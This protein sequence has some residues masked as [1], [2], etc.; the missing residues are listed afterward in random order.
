V[1]VALI[2]ALPVVMWLTT[3]L[4]E[5]LP[6]EPVPAEGRLVATEMGRVYVEEIG[7]AGGTPVLLV[8][9]SVGWAGLWRET[10]AALAAAGYHAIAF[11]MPPMGWSDRDPAATYD[12]ATQGRRVLALTRA[13]G[14]RPVIVAHS[15]GAGAGAEA[16]MAE[17]ASFRGLVVV[18]GAL[19]L[20][21]GSD[22]PPPALLRPHVLRELLA[23]ATVTNPW[24][25][26]PLVK[27]F[28]FRKDRAAPYVP[29]LGQPYGR[30]GATA[31]VADLVPTL[32][33][34]PAVPSADPDAWAALDLPL[35]L[36]WGAED[37][38][39]P[40]A[41]GQELAELTGAPLT[42]LDGIGHIPQM[43]DPAGFQA[44]LIAALRALEAEGGGG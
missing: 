39:T 44:A 15:F 11:D 33:A 21:Q 23:A 5:T 41:Q 19:G 17:P 29:L 1:A 18:A 37:T 12:R 38:T 4:R 6:Q 7:P 40:L 27:L 3:P 16:A 43:E 20:G 35:A 9:G 28:L 22:A 34:T 2:L 32:F 10:S 24:V 13:L 26:G 31:A 8:H 25:N 42:V 30:E 14:V 36:I